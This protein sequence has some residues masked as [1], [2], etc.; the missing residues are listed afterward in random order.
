MKKSEEIRK[1]Y[2][3]AGKKS[4]RK[5]LSGLTSKQISEYFRKIS[6]GES[7]DIK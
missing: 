3:S 6:R 4:V 2:S 7:P 1:L 5:R